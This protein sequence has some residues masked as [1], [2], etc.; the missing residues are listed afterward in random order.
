MKPEVDAAKVIFMVPKD[1]VI[2]QPGRTV[3]SRQFS[4]YSRRLFSK[5]VLLRTICQDCGLDNFLHWQIQL[6][7]MIIFMDLLP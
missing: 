3:T 1:L 5:S 4:I 7:Q 2:T 6:P